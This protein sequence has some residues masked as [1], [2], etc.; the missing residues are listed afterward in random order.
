[1]PNLPVQ[2]LIP[3]SKPPL[4]QTTMSAFEKL[5]Q[6]IRDLIYDHCLI[7]HESIIPFPSLDERNLIKF[8][9]REPAKLWL[10]TIDPKFPSTCTSKAYAADWPTVALLGVNK[11][12]QHD[13]A[14][15][16]FGK[17]TW[18]LSFIG[19]FPNEEESQFWCRYAKF[20]R[21]VS[22]RFSMND[23]LPRDLVHLTRSLH[24]AHSCD[25]ERS[26]KDRL[27]DDRVD[28]LADTFA[29]K[30]R[31]LLEMDL[32][33]LVFDVENLFCPDGCC[34]S[35]ML[36]MLREYMGRDEPWYAVKAAGNTTRSYFRGSNP[37]FEYFQD[38]RTERQM[39]L[40]VVGLRDD[41]EKDIFEKGWG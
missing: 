16:L 4:H 1:M 33:S 3:P 8:D 10:G 15:I 39:I 36:Y 5:P 21:H 25:E 6:E 30:Q 7:H 22:T 26:L 28:M 20:F 32:A 17:N 12:V 13:A 18:H 11:T 2:H 9:G 41:E 27:H 29:W 37:R 19:Y 23:L 24:S 38:V 14:K 31:L 35:D 40:E 34:R